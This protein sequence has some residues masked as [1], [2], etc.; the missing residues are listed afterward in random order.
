MFDLNCR[1]ILWTIDHRFRSNMFIPVYHT[2]RRPIKNTIGVV[3]NRL[4]GMGL[5]RVRDFYCTKSTTLSN[6]KEEKVIIFYIM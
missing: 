2:K 3:M 4:V 5:N 1:P 6:G